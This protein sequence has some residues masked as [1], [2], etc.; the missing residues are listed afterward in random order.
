M[1]EE[2]SSDSGCEAPWMSLVQRGTVFI[3]VEDTIHI[4]IFLN[5]VSGAATSETMH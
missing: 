2:W 3:R 1:A 4:T 5:L